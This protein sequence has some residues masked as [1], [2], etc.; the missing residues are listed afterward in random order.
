MFLSSQHLGL[1]RHGVWNV[2]QTW[3]IGSNL[4]TG[5]QHL[6]SWICLGRRS[7]PAHY[8]S[9]KY[10]W[11][12]GFIM[13][14][15]WY[16]TENLIS[17]YYYYRSDLVRSEVRLGLTHVANIADILNSLWYCCD[18]FLKN[19]RHNIMLINLII[20]F[21][22]FSLWYCHGIYDIIGWKMARRL[23]FVP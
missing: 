16:F 2:T 8:P 21:Y 20:I 19:S 1:S 3:T 13:I 6:S 17:W 23:Y 15:L 10:C 18:I 4:W 12:F 7:N 5:Q 14:L 11:Y 22:L 9:C